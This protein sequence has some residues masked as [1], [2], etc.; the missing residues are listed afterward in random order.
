MK[1]KNY[2]KEKRPSASMAWVLVGVV[3]GVL[4]L[5]VALITNKGDG[6][7]SKTFAGCIIWLPIATLGSLIILALLGPVVENEL[8]NIIGTLS[9]TITPL[10]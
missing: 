7:V 3:F 10:P 1:E 9:P 4:G 5:I 6:R 8:S 2:E